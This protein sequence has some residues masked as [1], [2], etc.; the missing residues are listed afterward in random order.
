VTVRGATRAQVDWGTEAGYREFDGVTHAVFR[1]E[2]VA[3]TG[4]TVEIALH[5]RNDFLSALGLR[6]VTARWRYVV[7]QGLIAEQHHLE[8]DA[9]FA[10]AFR[11]FTAWGRTA[12][13]SRWREVL[14]PDGDVRF[15]RHTAP[16]LVALA[17][18]WTRERQDDEVAL[19]IAKVS[20]PLDMFR[21]A[22]PRPRDRR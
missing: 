1:Y 22:P 20:L 15:N 18:E 6:G 8:A 17:R 21:V 5:E 10:A 11:R 3:V 4:N 2:V 16:L 7:Q 19:R 13:P 14:G 12:R 9:A